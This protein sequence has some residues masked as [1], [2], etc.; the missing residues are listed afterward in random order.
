MPKRKRAYWD[1]D[2]KQIKK[3]KIDKAEP[4]YFDDAYYGIATHGAWC[5]SGWS[6]NDRQNSVVGFSTAVDALDQTCKEHD[7]GIA[8]GEDRDTLDNEFIKKNRWKGVKSHIA[9]AAVRAEKHRRHIM[10]KLRGT[11]YTTPA[12]GSSSRQKY[13]PVGNR[14]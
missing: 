1:D 4:G 11:D 12:R 6:D 13:P 14:S 7:I 9:A 3:E 5:G 8:K 2:S 10:G